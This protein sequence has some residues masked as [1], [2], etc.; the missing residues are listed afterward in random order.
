M[1]RLTTLTVFVHVVENGGFSAAARRLNMSTTTVSSHI[2]SLEDRLG[3]RLLNRTTRR[4]SLTD[5]GKAYYERSTQILSDLEE[6]DQI[7]SASQSTPR[8][9]LS[10]YTSTHIIRFIAPVVTEYLSLYPGVTV[11]LRIGEHMIDLVG[12]GVDLAIRTLPPP[13][14]T[15]IVRRLT[16]W[17]HVLCCTPAYLEKHEAP[18]EPADLAR[19]NCLRYALHPFG[20]EWRFTD[21]RGSMASVHVSGNLITNSG[22][23]LRV[24]A[25]AGEGLFLAPPFVTMDDF[26]AGRLV[27][28]MPEYRPVE[29]AINAIYQHRQHL[30]AK[31]RSF[32]DLLAQR[33]TEHRQW[34]LPEQLDARK[35]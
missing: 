16:N 31:V 8:G 12:E 32:I 6:A 24:A 3:V 35:T 4:V 15:L 28:I 14:S 22:E 34:M 30:S 9:T 27:P 23:T 25:L 2:Q 19:H 11:D 21:A 13:D 1:D 17:R 20:N 10:L 33:I 18:K 7:A 26:E 5:I 29:F